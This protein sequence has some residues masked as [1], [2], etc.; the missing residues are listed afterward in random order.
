MNAARTF[1]SLSPHQSS[2][3]RLLRLMATLLCAS[4]LAACQTPTP[5]WTACAGDAPVPVLTGPG[6]DNFDAPAPTEPAPHGLRGACPRD[7]PGVRNFAEVAAHR[8]YRSAQP[9]AEE[10]RTL[11]EQVGIKTVVNLRS[12]HSD[13]PA[14]EAAGLRYIEIPFR[15][16]HAEP[17]DVVRFLQIVTDPANQPVLVH[18][19]HGA[20]RTGTMV[21]IYR[22]YVQGWS[23]DEALGELPRFGFHTIWGNLPAFLRGDAWRQAARKAGIPKGGSP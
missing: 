2:L 16:W 18:C 20:D 1:P 6:S 21:A 22:M 9:T 23:P 14:A 7:L 12:A 13:L 11:R 15:P 17:E 5:A 19:Q 10:F 8:L 3:A 4:L